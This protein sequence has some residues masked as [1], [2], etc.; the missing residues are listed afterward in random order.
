MGVGLAKMH[1]EIGGGFMEWCIDVN[2]ALESADQLIML[3]N[4][5]KVLAVRRGQTV[6]YMPRWSEEADSQS[7]HI[8][9]SLRDG[10][11]KPLF[12]D[13][14]DEHHMSDTSSAACSDTCRR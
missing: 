3:R 9:V 11:G 1:E 14:D 2:T 7:T 10:N 8:H 5:L 4:F 13:G 6:C 12:F